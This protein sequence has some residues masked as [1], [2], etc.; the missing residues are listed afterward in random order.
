MELLVTAASGSPL[1][2]APAIRKEIRALDSAAVVNR[3]TTVEESVGQSLDARKFQ[4]LL[5]T[6]LSALALLLAAIGIFGM[7]IHSVMRRTQEIGIRMALGASRG[8]VIAMIVTRGMSLTAAGMGIGIGGSLALARVLQTLLFDVEPVDPLSY[9]SAIA[10]L[11]GVA[12]VACWLPA[13][14]TARVDPA[15]ALRHD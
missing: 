10:I 13:M 14:R 6:L 5:L 8:D 15:V 7:M 11:A 1:A 3:V 2:L 4:T 9:A 12:L